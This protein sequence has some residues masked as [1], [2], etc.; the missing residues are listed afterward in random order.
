MDQ[1]GGVSDHAAVAN[2]LTRAAKASY[3]DWDGGFTL[4]FWRCHKGFQ[5]RARDGVPL[6]ISSQTLPRYRSHQ[7]KPKDAIK[8]EMVRSKLAKVRDR[9]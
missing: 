2:I 5:L 4:N 6:F 9:S 1:V 7:P 3:W 8:A